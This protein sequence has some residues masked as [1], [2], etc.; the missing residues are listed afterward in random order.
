M[1]AEEDD[2]FDWEGAVEQIIE[3]PPPT[4]NFYEYNNRPNFFPNS[5]NRN[6]TEPQIRYELMLLNDQLRLYMEEKEA[7][8]QRGYTDEFIEGNIRRIGDAILQVESY[9]PSPQKRKQ[10]DLPEPSQKK[11]KGQGLS[12]KGKKHGFIRHI[13]RMGKGLTLH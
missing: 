4:Y 6:S 2:E 7:L 12:Y 1:A 10:N 9:L 11:R 5:V 3:A 13:A 8:L